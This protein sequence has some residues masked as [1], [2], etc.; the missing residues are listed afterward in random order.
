MHKAQVEVQVQ[1]RRK[2]AEEETSETGKLIWVPS[3]CSLAA[4]WVE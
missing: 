2:G 3:G 1:G 4:E